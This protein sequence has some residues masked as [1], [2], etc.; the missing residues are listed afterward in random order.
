M[1]NLNAILKFLGRTNNSG[2]SLLVSTNPKINIQTKET[3][4]PP[5]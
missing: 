4:I 3:Q 2:G 1:G 5:V